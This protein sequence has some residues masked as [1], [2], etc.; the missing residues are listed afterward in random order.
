MT[1]L[2]YIYPWRCTG[3]AFHDNYPWHRFHDTFSTTSVHDTYPWHLFHDTVWIML[4][5]TLQRCVYVLNIVSMQATTA[6]L[7][8]ATSLFVSSVFVW[9]IA[10]ALVYLCDSVFGASLSLSHVTS[11]LLVTHTKPTLTSTW[12]FI[13]T[14]FFQ[15]LPIIFT[16]LRTSARYRF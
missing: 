4:S 10:S 13:T 3:F 2:H 7:F 8:L 12:Q 15:H 6:I 9:V 14:I 5:I 1:S 16:A 11:R